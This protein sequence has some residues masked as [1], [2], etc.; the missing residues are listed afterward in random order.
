M[1][2]GN[3]ACEPQ[4]GGFRS[5]LL[6]K[7]GYGGLLLLDIKLPSSRPNPILRGILLML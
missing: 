7:L 5:A 6:S 2:H 4:F 1:R 3:Y